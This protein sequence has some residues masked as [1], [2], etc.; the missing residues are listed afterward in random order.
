VAFA[1]SGAVIMVTQRTS[2]D[3]GPQ[4]GIAIVAIA[5]GAV[6][7]L[8]TIARSGR[9]PVEAPVSG[10]ASEPADDLADG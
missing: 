5:V 3:V 2:I 8:V 7:L 6:T 1:I 9:D 4:W 10:A